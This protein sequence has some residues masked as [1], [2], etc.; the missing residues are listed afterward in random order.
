MPL[1]ESIEAIAQEVC[2]INY[3]IDRN[4]AENQ[5]QCF[6]LVMT[7]TNNKTGHMWTLKLLLMPENGKCSEKCRS[8]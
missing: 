2:Y 6:D 7:V 3:Q 1:V 5:A 8:K 4:R